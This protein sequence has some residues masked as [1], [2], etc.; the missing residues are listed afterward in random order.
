[1]QHRHRC[2]FAAIMTI[3]LTSAT[4]SMS[5]DSNRIIL[6]ISKSKYYALRG[7]IGA[8]F[9]ESSFLSDLG[10]F[11][12]FS[13]LADMNFNEKEVNSVGVLINASH[14]LGFLSGRIDIGAYK[15]IKYNWLAT[16]TPEIGLSILEYIGLYY[17]F[18]INAVKP[19][20]YPL[21]SHRISF[22]VSFCP[23]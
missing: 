19:S 6:G 5:S 20:E 23:D 11:W 8:V 7:G 16:I 18:D 1:M 15:G 3:V 9:D 14:S 4:I 21:T 17:G 12:G 13:I 10:K 22:G 2:S